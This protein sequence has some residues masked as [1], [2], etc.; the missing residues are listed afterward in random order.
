MQYYDVVLE[1]SREAAWDMI[2]IAGVPKTL[3]KWLVDLVQFAEEKQRTMSMKWTTFNMQP[4]LE[5]EQQ[6]S[7]WFYLEAS[8]YED[9]DES[10]E[11]QQDCANAALAWKYALLIYIARVFKWDRT[12]DQ[13]PSGIGPL[14]RL[15]LDHVRCCRQSST[16]QKQVLLPVF[17]AGSEATDPYARKY[18]TDYCA[19]WYEK[20]R[21]RMFHDAS[22]LLEEIW[23]EQTSPQPNYNIWWGSV[24]DSKGGDQSAD[25]ASKPQYL[26]G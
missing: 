4:V 11:H 18:A 9:D 16:V 17:L 23:M 12:S 6:I 3:F 14:S 1:E 15:C 24:L 13:R 19:Y 20:C 21:Y 5:L 10:F 8:D 2:S 22:C 25:Q 26:F 7:N